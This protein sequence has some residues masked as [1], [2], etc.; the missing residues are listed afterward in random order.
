MSSR[1]CG[2]IGVTVFVMWANIGQP[3]IAQVD[4]VVTR[5]ENSEKTAK[6]R[7]LITDW[8]GSSLSLKSGTRTREIDNDRIVEIQTNWNADYLR[9]EQL[10]DKGNTSEA[11][12]KLRLALASETRPWA[13]TIIRSELVRALL[14]A[15]ENAAAIEEFGKIVAVDPQTRFLYL[16][17]LPWSGSVGN[18]R[19]QELAQ[20]S[21]VS[22]DPVM[23]LIG[24]SWLTGG[25]DRAKAI[26]LLE[27][28]ANDF[29]SRIAFLAAGQLWRTQVATADE[30]KIGNWEQKILQMPKPLRAGPYYV[31]AMAQA[32]LN[33]NEKAAINFMRI[34]ILFPEQTALCAASLYKAARLLHNDGQTSEAR[35]LWSELLSDHPE[36]LWAKQVDASLLKTQNN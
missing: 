24:A 12:E 16:V 36:S 8:T 1:L 27:K 34:P 21:L 13:Q 5:S 30:S 22:R 15:E 23:Q 31:L 10:L 14:A 35:T 7:G 33:Q 32:R 26:Q 19:V 25:S 20:Q 29:E 2:T 6:R 17:P 9:G 4:T 11:A 18:A 28:L 3:G